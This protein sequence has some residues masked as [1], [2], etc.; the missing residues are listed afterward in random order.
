MFPAEL[1]ITEQSFNNGHASEVK[2]SKSGS[3][4][5]YAFL[6]TDT[7]QQQLEH[8]RHYLGGSA[9]RFLSLLPKHFTL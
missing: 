4:N 8:C 3:N 1:P 6:I 5:S 2:T 7:R 9:F